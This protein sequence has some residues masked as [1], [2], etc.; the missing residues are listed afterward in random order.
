MKQT[1]TDSSNKEDVLQYC[2]D[3]LSGNILANVLVKQSV[4]RFLSDIERPDIDMRWEILDRFCDFAGLFHH[5]TGPTN[6]VKFELLPWQ[7]FFVA[8]MIC[9]YKGESRKVR[10]VLFEVGRKNGKSTLIAVLGL[11]FFI[12]DGEANPE[13]Y[14]CS[15]SK[16]QSKILFKMCVNFLKQIKNWDKKFN[17][18]RDYIE[19]KDGLGFLKCMPADADTLDGLNSHVT[20]L[21][22][23]GAAKDSRL[24]DVMDSSQKFRQNPLSIVLTTANYTF[25]GPC[26]QYQKKCE[27]ILNGTFEDD[28]Q[29]ALCYTLDSNDDWKDKKMYIKANPC[30]G[31]TLSEDRLY[32]ECISSTAVAEME[33]KIKTC[34]I[35]L[36]SEKVWI[37]N[38][39]VERCY[40]DP[41]KYPLMILNVRTWLWI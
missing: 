26:F 19:R 20:L 21:D 36:N 4:Q 27:N 24:K 2:N 11:Y 40:C 9:M 3:I 10:Q 5:Y 41:K 39:V 38:N 16:D 35:W 7:K 18:Y 34:N 17:I 25:G 22:E 15:N 32:E 23:Y 8:G 28:R 13:I 30:I 1:L 37:P 31:Y 29:F 12:A 14:C 6:G 33:F